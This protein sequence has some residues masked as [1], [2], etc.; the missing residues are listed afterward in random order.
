MNDINRSF[1][2]Q[3][4]TSNNIYSQIKFNKIENEFQS[5]VEGISKEDDMYTKI[6][7]NQTENHFQP[8]AEITPTEENIYYDEIVYYDGGG[9]EGW[10]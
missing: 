8:K 6:Q 7:F 2:I 3:F 4:N 10:L 9:V 5:K 1:E